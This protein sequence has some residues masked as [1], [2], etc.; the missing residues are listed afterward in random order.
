LDHYLADLTY[1]WNIASAKAVRPFVMASLGVA[2]MMTPVS[3][4]SRFAFGL[5]TGVKIFPKPHW[6]FRFS[7]EYLPT[8]MTS[9]VQRVTC[10]TGCVVA[11]SGGLL[12]QF[13]FSVGPVFR[14]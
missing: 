5:G 13:D 1:E 12:N 10:V 3:S 7:V 8:V 9:D 2:R 11:L 6:G 14:F 4:N